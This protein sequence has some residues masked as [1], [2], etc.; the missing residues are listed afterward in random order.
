MTL[1]TPELATPVA[2]PNRLRRLRTN[3]A[4]RGLAGLGE[5]GR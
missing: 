2:S 3:P 5:T 4:I 1:I